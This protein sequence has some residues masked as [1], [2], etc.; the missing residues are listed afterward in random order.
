MD[1]KVTDKS[2]IDYMTEA[3]DFTHIINSLKGLLFKGI[4][5]SVT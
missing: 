3:R 5:N 4:S 1:S 2:G